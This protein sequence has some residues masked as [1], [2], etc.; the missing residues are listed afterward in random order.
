VANFEAIKSYVVSIGF[1]VDQP[2]L[3]RVQAT[4][5]DTV[6]HVEE[7]TTGMFK[8]VAIAAGTV[9]TAF[10]GIAT[11]AVAMAHHV[12]QGEMEFQKYALH[13]NM[14]VDAAKKMKIGLEALGATLAEVFWN[15][16]L[17]ERFN[18]L[19]RDQARLQAG[20]GAD[21][22]QQM[23]N[24]RDIEFEF[25]RFRVALQY[26]QMGIV[27]ALEKAFGMEEGG[28]LKRLKAFNDL[29][30]KDNRKA[31]DSLAHVLKPIIIDVGNAILDVTSY[32]IKFIGRLSGDKRLEDG[33]VSLDNIKNTF[34]D[35]INLI[36]PLIDKL[37]QLGNRL[38]TIAG[39]IDK[40]IGPLERHPELTERLL[41]ATAGG[42]AFGPVGAAA[43][44]IAG[45]KIVDLATM[46]KE[47][48]EAKEDAELA[49]SSAW[50]QSFVRGQRAVRKYIEEGSPLAHELFGGPTQGMP[51]TAPTTPQKPVPDVLP[52]WMR[53]STTAIPGTNITPSTDLQ[54]TF[55]K[56]TG[57]TKAPAT[58]G[59][60][61]I[62]AAMPGTGMMG[63]ATHVASWLSEHMPSL[64]GLEGVWKK[65][66]QWT[67]ENVIKTVGAVAKQMGVPP[68]I[69]L[70]VAK[71]ESN[72]NPMAISKA[73]AQG[74]MQL[75][76]GTAAGM[77]VKG[78]DDVLGNIA[79]GIGYLKKL[80]EQFHDWRLALMAY[81][82]GPGNVQNWMKR[83][84]GAMPA[85]TA[86]YV[87]KVLSS[88][89]NV[90]G[91]TINVP[92]GSNPQAIADMVVKQIEQRLDKR[93]QRQLA[94]QGVYP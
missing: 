8:V 26:L 91:I 16:E 52:D 84:G 32:F 74:V 88:A 1:E 23:K 44:F 38:A 86:A 20:L 93:V 63:L 24:L 54:E 89:V 46:T 58:V 19:W 92:T 73:G 87:P 80:Y 11:A 28:L 78:S 33:K 18:Q 13:M 45:P 82:W 70:S 42:T 40:I 27:S 90:G 29:F 51:P 3:Q 64:S 79:G 15:P 37:E 12:A 77:G 75:M 7:M 71:T 41:A 48:Q 47:Q 59:G 5:E 94:Q 85:E 25:T 81:N 55:R 17:R 50:Y 21:Y 49:G 61:P 62:G 39:W 22:Q 68:E 2:E 53:Q 57:Q 72:F 14:N 69:A 66:E 6:R 34:V 67:R 65:G 4:I 43:G 76:P 56:A 35:M 83:G 30:I 36:P 9:V 60:A 31:A 10:T